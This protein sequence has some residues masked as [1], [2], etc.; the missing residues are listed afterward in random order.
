M[1]NDTV[2][3]TCTYDSYFNVGNLLVCITWGKRCNSVKTIGI[4][5][6]FSN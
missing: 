5:I 1:K 2:Y 3:N 6:L 4:F